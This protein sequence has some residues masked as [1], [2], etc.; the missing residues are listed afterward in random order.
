MD[1]PIAED[2]DYV[3]LS[4]RSSSVS[5]SCTSRFQN[6]IDV[7]EEAP[8]TAAAGDSSELTLT[9]ERGDSLVRRSL[10]WQSKPQL[11]LTTNVAAQA[12]LLRPSGAC[13]FSQSSRSRHPSENSAA[14]GPQHAGTRKSAEEF[15]SG[16][17]L[18]LLHRTM[19]LST[20]VRAA[21]AQSVS[22]SPSVPSAPAAERPA[23][24]FFEFPASHST[25]SN[26]V[27]MQRSAKGQSAPNL[28]SSFSRE[29]TNHSSVREEIGPTGA[30]VVSSSASGGGPAS[31][32]LHLHSPKS[33][34]RSQQ[35]PVG[36]FALITGRSS[37]RIESTSLE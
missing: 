7:H 33:I 14:A 31:P 17:G 18:R 37:T 27:R 4:S 25:T 26:L 5:T 10:S 9:R 22:E 6:S 3:F 29:S 16:R 19:S 1:S 34:G 15:Q 23:A 13:H 30:S 35:L 2:S 28:A 12:L 20:E 36:A 11:G 21:R 24:L 8:Q 32:K